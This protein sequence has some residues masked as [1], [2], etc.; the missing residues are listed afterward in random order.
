[1][2]TRTQKFAQAGIGVLL[3]LAAGAPPAMADDTEL[4]LMMPEFSVKPNILFML[5]T[6]GSMD[7]IVLTKEPYDPDGTYSDGGCDPNAVYW[8]DVDVAPSCSSAQYLAK[9]SFECDAAGGSLRG[10]GIYTDTMVQ[11]RPTSTP[12]VSR[13]QE[14]ES[15][16]HAGTVECMA[17]S[18][19]HGDGTAGEV[20]ATNNDT[21]GSAGYTSD[22]AHELAWGSA[23]ATVTYT[24]YDGKYL[25]WKNTAP[26]DAMVP[27][28]DILKAVTT[29]VLNSI[30]GVNVGIMRFNDNDGGIVI[31]A[32]SDLDTNRAGILAAVDG[33]P[34]QGN[35]P[36]AEVMYEGAQYWRGGAPYFGNGH[37]ATDPA[38][39]STTGTYN[40]PATQQCSK[41]FNILLSDGEPQ[42][43]NDEAS[44]LAGTNLPGFGGCDGGTGIG[45]CLD[46]IAQYLFT[47]DIDGDPD[48]DEQVVV[49]THTIGFDVDVQN[50]AETAADADGKYF[51]ANDV[52][53]LTSTLL[54]IFDDIK[55]RSLSFASPGISVNAFNRTQHLNDLYITV[56]EADTKVHWPGNLKKY[57]IEGGRIVDAAGQPAVDPANGFFNVRDIWGDSDRDHGTDASLGGA[58]HRLP[59]PD[60][61]IL[62]TNSGGA[63]VGVNSTNVDS[64]DLDLTGAAGEPTVDELLGWMHG[65]DVRN[66]NTES[67]TRYA[68]GDPLH[69]QPAAVVYGGNASSPDVVVFVGT[70]DGYLHAIQGTGVDAGKELWAF[71]PHEFLGDMKRLFFNPSSNF[72]HYGIDGNIVPV[73]Y[74]DDNNGIIEPGEGDF[75]YIVFGLR[76]GGHSYYA[77]DVTNKTSPSLLWVASE[78]EF[79]FGQTW[80]TPVIARV[81][82]D[83][84]DD[85]ADSN[86]ELKTRD[87]VVIVGG[88]YDPVHDTP[89][90][91]TSA[92]SLGTGIYMLDLETGDPRWWS[93]DDTGIVGMTRAFPTQVKAVDMS[94][95]GYADRMY[96]ADVGGRIWRFDIANGEADLVDGGIIADLGTPETAS[97]PRRFYN[98]PDVA[99]FNDP[100]Q[101]RRFVSIS[102][103]SGYRAHPLNQDSNDMFFSVRDPHVFTPIADY[104]N[105]D[106]IT[107]DDLVTVGPDQVATIG[108]DK[109]GWKFP[110]PSE[111]AILADSLTFNDT[112]L[113]VSFSPVDNTIDPCHPTAGRNF[114][115]QVSV[116]NGSFAVNNLDSPIDTDPEDNVTEIAQGGIAPGATAL[117]PASDDA[118]CQGPECAEQ[119]IICFGAECFD[120]GFANNPVR[121][122]W[123]QDGIQ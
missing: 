108:A 118:A 67:E 56:F 24:V 11:L 48:N 47:N 63:L 45:A 107:V 61:R 76:R 69:S 35:T 95:D 117:F 1:M 19:E 83:D 25:N 100:F 3:A 120:P 64:A 36:L 121:T 96:A 122:L 18:G 54:N 77:L 111:Q 44:Q 75:V 105:Y 113:F 78:P 53:S 49:R 90:A 41:N 33:L 88:G 74:D 8:T 92:D 82:T 26:E 29:A 65:R 42:D 101:G 16:N 81:D 2:S 27:K 79:A 104:S 9:S 72:K 46:D 55:K 98:S 60:S 20:Y 52:E 73:V 6:S 13:W 43:S 85:P 103:G 86:A 94:G 110:L 123:T 97:V 15:G 112:V 109:D 4:M 34:A 70:N 58:A 62:W 115:H 99:I 7:G 57:R 116:V 39:V 93:D 22:P 114:A 10:L 31:E 32:M 89:A 119:P 51:L 12:D 91:P 50:L 37:P 17:D 14:L 28:I 87:A 23:P 38:A 30:D 80:S 40:A 84:A 106:V 68:M 21:D 71:V 66:E 5:D 102:I 59:A